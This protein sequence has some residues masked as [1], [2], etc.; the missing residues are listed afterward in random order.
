MAKYMWGFLADVMMRETAGIQGCFDFEN[1]E[2]PEEVDLNVKGVTV[3]PPVVKPDSIKPSDLLP[4]KK[5]EKEAPKPAPAAVVPEK[6]APKPEFAPIPLSTVPIN[7]SKK[8]D[9]NE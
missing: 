2:N 9:K 8:D 3:V 7:N 4:I 1:E 5:K 6:A